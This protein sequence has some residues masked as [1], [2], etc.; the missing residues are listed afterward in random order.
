MV[1]CADARHPKPREFGAAG[2]FETK[3]CQAEAEDGS[4]RAVVFFFS[5]SMFLSGAPV[6]SQGGHAPSLI[7]WLASDGVVIGH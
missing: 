3:A 1:E 6:R 5:G 7:A 4:Q 2:C